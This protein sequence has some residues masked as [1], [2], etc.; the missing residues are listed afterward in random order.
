LFIDEIHRLNRTCEEILYPAM[1]DSYIDL[2]VG[3]G[4][5]AQ[6]IKI[7]LKPFTLVGAT[8]RSGMLTA[9]LKARFG[10]DLKLEFYDEKDLSSIII[11]TSKLFNLKF[12]EDAARIISKRS[13]MTPRVANKLVRRI[14]D[15]ATVAHLDTVDEQ[16]AVQCLDKLGIDEL[17]LVDLDR[18][19]LK[20]MIERY[21]GGPV[22]IKTLAA[23]IDEEERTIEE[24]HEPFMLRIGLW[25]KT[26][27]GRR[28]TKSGFGHMGFPYG[29]VVKDAEQELF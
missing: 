29:D 14:R 8:T 25:E 4:V 5:S 17:G 19:L 27:Q 16:F 11:R 13:R 23:L 28:V 12:T 22:G 18:T 1:E 20:L 2:I 15:Y 9:P 26:A 3:E 24:D 7:N 6:S 10:I 21:N